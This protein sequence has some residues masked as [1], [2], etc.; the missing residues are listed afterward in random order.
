MIKKGIKKVEVIVDIIC[1]KC[2]RSLKSNDP[3]DPE[4][5]G[6]TSA[7]VSGGYNSP[8]LGDCTHYSFSLCEYCLKELFSS[9]Q[10][11]ALE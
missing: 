3:D 9:F 6:L 7:N 2:N 4:Y 8:V 10:I 5:Y 11:D 1:N